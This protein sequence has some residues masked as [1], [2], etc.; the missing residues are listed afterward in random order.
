MKG[1]EFGEKMLAAMVQSAE[2]A[3]SVQKPVFTSQR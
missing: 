1:A 2:E 3:N